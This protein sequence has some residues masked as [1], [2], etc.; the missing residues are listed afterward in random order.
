MKEI[1]RLRIQPNI[2]LKPEDHTKPEQFQYYSHHFWDHPYQ[3]NL[4]LY[5]AGVEDAIRK[6]AT[7]YRDYSSRHQ[8]LVMAPQGEIIYKSPEQRFCLKKNNILIIP[9]G[10]EFYFETSTRPFYRKLVLFILGVNLPGIMETLE[11]NRME[12]IAVPD[13]EPYVREILKLDGMIAARNEKDMAKMSGMTLELL[14]EL[15]GCKARVDE[16]LMMARIVKSRLVAD[17][18]NPDAVSKIAK[19]LRLNIRTLNRIFQEKFN[20]APREFR[21]NYRIEKAK[22][23]LCRSDM[24][25]KEIAQKLGYCNQFYFC[26]EFKRATGISPRDFR[27]Q[28]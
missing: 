13:I 7:W 24:T 11:L 8:M 1:S 22:D 25:V 28:A 26:N 3:E 4:P 16:S 12:M 21:L 17:L 20:M 18:E 6:T 23:F 19:E 15:A 14:Y 5:P 2:E 27:N 9:Q 10:Q